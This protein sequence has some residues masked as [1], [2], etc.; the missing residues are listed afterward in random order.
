LTSQAFIETY[1]LQTTI[2]EVRRGYII[3]VFLKG[4]ELLIS[5]ADFAQITVRQCKLCSTVTK[6][7]PTNWVFHPINSRI[8]EAKDKPAG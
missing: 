1:T 7:T 6:C 8:S 4:N 3:P 5:Q 2:F